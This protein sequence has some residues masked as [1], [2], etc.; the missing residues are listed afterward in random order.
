MRAVHPLSHFTHTV[1]PP[2]SQPR[3]A[4]SFDSTAPALEAQAPKPRDAQT[5]TLK[6][7]NP[8]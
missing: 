4:R 5:I 8:Q 7:T 3:L 2:L 6:P 1:M